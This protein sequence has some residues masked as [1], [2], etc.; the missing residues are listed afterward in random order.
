M[1]CR[2]IPYTSLERTVLQLSY[3]YITTIIFFYV[4]L[5]QRF[6]VL[7]VNELLQ[8]EFPSPLYLKLR[9]EAPDIYFSCQKNIY[10]EK[11]GYF[12]TAPELNGKASISPYQSRF[13]YYASD[14]TSICCFLS[15]LSVSEHHYVK[16]VLTTCIRVFTSD[17]FPAMIYDLIGVQYAT[18]YI[19]F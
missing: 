1:I 5:Y 13:G 10:I 6:H 19:F 11:I 7:M 3:I 15:S 2:D 12:T 16:I 4:L 9:D 17:R 8:V 14:I 18:S